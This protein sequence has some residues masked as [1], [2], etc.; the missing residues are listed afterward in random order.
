MEVNGGHCCSVTNILQVSHKHHDEVFTITTT[1]KMVCKRTVFIC[2][3]EQRLALGS[4]THAGAGGHRDPIHGPFLQ[5]LQ[6]DVV[7]AGRHRRLLHGLGAD[8]GPAPHHRVTHYVPGQRPVLALGR[9]RAP[10]YQQGGGA[11]AGACNVLRRGGG[12]CSGLRGGRGEVGNKKRKDGKEKKK[13]IK[14]KTQR[15]NK[16][17]QTPK[18]K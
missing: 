8:L 2:A 10:T 3:A 6:P 16:Q 9:R 17:Q 12:L 5:P 1:I 13:M 15:K 4:R 11:G 14:G 7:G 18:R